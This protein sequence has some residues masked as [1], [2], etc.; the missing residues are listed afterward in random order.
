MLKNH[1]KQLLFSVVL[2]KSNNISIFMQE[3]QNIN[4]EEEF[5]E[6]QLY[7]KFKFKCVKGCCQC[8][9]LSKIALY[10]FDIMELCSFLNLKTK[11]FH[12]EYTHF[13]FEDRV[14]RCY[15]KTK[16]N[17]VFFD[18][19]HAC[20]VYDHRPVRCRIFPVARIFNKGGTIKYY[21]PRQNCQGSESGKK[22]TIEEWI[23][24]FGIKEKDDLVKE[25]ACFVNELKNNEK[26]I[27]SDKLFLMLFKKIFY[28]F[29]NELTKDNDK[30]DYKDRMANL[31]NLAKTYLSD[32]EKLKKGYNEF[33]KDGF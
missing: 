16:P 21:L 33:F 25:W 12:K 10:A 20:T 9:E 15:L 3:I 22:Y 8:C 28:D 6:K 23:E 24:S 7:N 27:L 19:T 14:L 29:D 30:N 31:Y 11:E 1:R 2:D 4:F 5:Q 13:V 18:K 17:C 26:I 32:F